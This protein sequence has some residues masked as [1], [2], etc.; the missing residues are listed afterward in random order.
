[1]GAI[2][3]FGDKYGDRVRVVRAGSHSLEFCGG[4]HVD[5]LGDIG[6]IQI[7]SESSIGS[8]TRRIEAV[9]ALGA[10]RRSREMERALGSVATLLKTSLEDVVPS[11]ERLFERQ[12]DIE[13]EVADAAP[14]PAR[15]SSPSSCTPQR[16]GDVLVARV[17]GYAGEQL[18]TLAQDLQR[19]GRRAVVLAGAQRRQGRPSP[20][21]PTTTLDAQSDGQGARGP[22]GRRWRRLG[23]PG[24]RR[25]TRRRRASTGSSTPRRRSRS[26]GARSSAIDPGTQA[27]RRRDHGLGAD[28]WPSPARPS[29][30]T[31][32]WPASRAR[33]SHEEVGGARGRRAPGLPL[34]RGAPRATDAA[35]ELFAA[36][37]RARSPP[38]AVRPV[39]RAPHDHRGAERSLSRGRREGAATSAAASTAPPRSCMLQHYLDGAR[40]LTR[41]LRRASRVV[42]GGLVARRRRVVRAPGLSRSAVR[43]RASSS[44][45]TP[46]DSMSP[47]R[48]AT[49]TPTGVIGSPFAFRVRRVDL[50]PADPSIRA[51]PTRSP[52]ARP[53]P[54]CARSSVA[55]PTC[56]SIVVT[57]GMTVHEVAAATSPTIR[58]NTF[59]DQFLADASARRGVAIPPRPAP[60]S[61]RAARDRERPRGPD[62]PGA[63]PD[64]PR[65]RRPAAA[66]SRRMHRGLRRRGAA[67]SGSRPA[68]TL[69]GLDAYQLRHRRLH[70]REGGLLPFEHAQGRPG[71]LQPPRAR[72]AAADGLDGLVRARAST[73][74]T[75][76]PAMLQ[77]PTPYNTYLQRRADADADLRRVDRRRSHAVL[78]AA[79]RDRGCT[80]CWSTRRATMAFSTTYAEQLANEAHRAARTASDE[81]A[82]RRRRLPDR[83]LALA[84]L[85]EAGLSPW[86]ASRAPSTRVRARART[87]AARLRDADGHARSTRCRSR[88]RSRA[89]RPRSATS[90]TTRRARTG[91]V[92]SLLGATGA[93]S[94]R[95]PTGRASSTR[96][97]ASFGV[98][99]AGLHV[100]VL[101]AGGAARA[102][103][104]ALVRRGA[105]AGRGASGRTPA[106]VGDRLAH[107]TPTSCDHVRRRPTGRPDRQHRARSRDARAGGAVDAGRRAR[108]HRRRHHLRAAHVARGARL[109]ERAG[110]SHAPTDWRCW[111]TRRRRQ[112]QLVVGR[113]RSTARAL[114]EVIA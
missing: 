80:S 62:R 56:P 110:L 47:D 48:R 83:A 1:M 112:M 102:I 111:P 89:S 86:R 108:H 53:S 10:F 61:L 94:A 87:E 79:A 22:G 105:R 33:W 11:L 46:G 44:R 73:A 93:C 84:A 101:G 66:G 67:A 68:T 103:V 13:K 91:V 104:D 70:R 5:R 37:A 8:N 4:T 71:H 3:F 65:A 81:V 92:N 32:A 25:R 88:C 45:C 60:P 41:P 76:T 75:V 82:P 98:S 23:A 21:R 30:R 100:V 85:H 58:G 55:R 57:P 90:S 74:G 16:R 78:H 99:V 14:G 43:A 9:S 38:I 18:R 63:L 95:R 24:A 31:T 49:C 7:V 27:L 59:A 40:V 26:R 34:G 107:A 109:H 106:R 64:H 42:V 96:C 15:R 52:R 77:T 35:D 36:L 113:A 72:R 69:E 6:Q 29:P 2:A 97:A 12:R 51:G 17:D 114:L 28:A 19:R 54:T 39:R 20:S 50:R